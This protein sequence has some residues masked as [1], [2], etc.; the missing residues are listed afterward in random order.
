MPLDI[1][2]KSEWK[3]SSSAGKLA[4][5]ANHKHLIKIDSSLEA[6]HAVAKPDIEGRIRALS[7]L[8]H[9]IENYGEVKRGANPQLS[10]KQR[11]K[12]EASEALYAQADAKREYFASVLGIERNLKG[13]FGVGNAVRI[14][15]QGEG[16]F[17]ALAEIVYGAIK[18]TGGP[19]QGRMLHE[20]YWTEA[21]DPLHRNWGHPTN[22]PVFKRWAK[23]R[24]EDGVTPLSFYRWFET[25]SDEDLQQLVPAGLLATQYQ[26]EAGREQFRVYVHGGKLKQPG[27][28]EVLE[29]FS[30][31]NY[32]TNFAGDGWS[33]FVISTDGKLY[34]NNHDDQAGWFHAAFMGGKPVIAAGE[35]YVRNG[36]LYAITPK[37]GHY[38]PRA[39]D[40]I[41]GLKTLS[42][43]GLNLDNAQAMAFVFKDGRG[44]LAKGGGTL[45]EWYD[46][47]IYQASGGTGGLLRTDGISK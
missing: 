38:K 28:N 13:M 44:V 7:N 32:R 16:R 22:S 21:I 1:M 19:S 11:R 39:T 4:I 30:T 35:L 3:K 5:R 43:G 25:L 45:C 23:L 15:T 20:S 17:K 31:A 2:T 8:M 14:Q 40:I 18:Y 29:L 10:V 9:V 46:A 41:N 37:S 6:Y 47:N 26:D 27:A 33:I 24:Y 42:D 12:I 36:I 34:A